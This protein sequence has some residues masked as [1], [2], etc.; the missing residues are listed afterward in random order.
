MNRAGELKLLPPQSFPGRMEQRGS[1]LV[2]ESVTPR[3]CNLL[4]QA[5]K[6]GDNTLTP[7]GEQ[8]GGQTETVQSL[9]FGQTSPLLV[10]DEQRLRAELHRETNGVRFADVGLASR[11]CNLGDVAT[12]RTSQKSG[13]EG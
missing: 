10:I 7:G 13:S 3:S 4:Q 2:S 5:G 1:R 12:A 11:R 9:G 6:R 8:D